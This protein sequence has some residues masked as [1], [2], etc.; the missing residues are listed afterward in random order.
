[1]HLTFARCRKNKKRADKNCRDCRII[2]QTMFWCNYVSIN[3]FFNWKLQ[4]ELSKWKSGF[5]MQQSWYSEKCHC[6]GFFLLI[7]LSLIVVYNPL[8][9]IKFM[10]CFISGFLVLSVNLCTLIWML[11]WRIF[12]ITAIWLVGSN[13]SQSNHVAGEDHLAMPTHV[14][15][16]SLANRGKKAKCSPMCPGRQVEMRQM[17]QDMRCKRNFC[18]M[19]SYYVDSQ[20]NVLQY[21][22]VM[23]VCL[24]LRYLI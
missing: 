2:E 3:L 10:S 7:K 11:H 20:S 8:S 18:L 19:A 22:F 24:H 13:K 23:L 14:F 16:V 12:T 17:F 1:M 5:I 9:L 15:N 21:S 4:Q 6:L